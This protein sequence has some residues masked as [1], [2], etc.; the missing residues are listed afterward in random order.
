MKPKII[1][2]GRTINLGVGTYESIKFE[3]EVEIEN[4]EDLNET[5]DKLHF[6]INRLFL[7]AGNISKDRKAQF[8]L[9]DQDR[10]SATQVE[11]AKARLENKP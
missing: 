3:I 7:L 2:I 10:F 6:E 5:A 11:W 4:D 1:R 9:E 8:I